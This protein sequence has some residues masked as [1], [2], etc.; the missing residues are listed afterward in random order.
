[1]KIESRWPDWKE[2]G[3][4]PD[5]SGDKTFSEVKAAVIEE[6]GEEALRRGWLEVC[7]SLETVTESLIKLGSDAVPVHHMDAL[8]DRGLSTDEQ[9]QIRTRGCCIVRGV[10]PKDEINSLFVDVKEFVTKN[11]GKISGWPAETQS[12]YNLYNSP[13]Q[14]AM[15]THPNEL[16]VQKLL[17]D[18]YRD[19]TGRTSTEPLS[20]TD[21]IRIRPPGQ[22]FL[23]LGPHIDAGSLARWADPKYR[24]VYDA[25][26]SG[27]PE[28]HDAFDL[29]V[30]QDADQFLFPGKAHSVIFRAF[31]GWT[32]LTPADAG[33]GTLLLYPDVKRVI[34]YLLLRPFFSPPENGEDVMDYT[35]W[36]FDATSTGFPGT[37]KP[38]SQRLSVT[39]HP[40]LRLR[41]CMVYIPRME[42]G[43]T[44]WWHADMCH[45]VDPDHQGSLDASVAYIGACPTTEINKRYVKSQ[46][47]AALAGKPPPDCLGLETD[48]TTLD[49]YKGFDHVSA[50]GKAALGFGLL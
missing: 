11:K 31:Q 4:G 25:I 43:D 12:I 40:H 39:S 5:N 44:V 50:E 18:L 9:D 20:Y 28:A 36:T 23:G 16:R 42:P 13:T 47:E 21:A 38:D 6:Y 15:R 29:G 14:V 2:Y 41:E 24:K 49:G 26:F 1:M 46:L 48:E 10:I 27:S 7:K 19:D 3:N 8:R 45:A 33:E 37:T 34:S 35:K 30:R 32:A 22:P 17:N